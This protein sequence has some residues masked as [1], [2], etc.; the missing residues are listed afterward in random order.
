MN[1]SGFMQAIQNLGM[2]LITMMSG[3]VVDKMGYLWLEYFFIFWLAVALLGT[4]VIWVMDV[5]GS[6]YLNMGI[7]QREEHDGEV[8][9]REKAAA[10]AQLR[11]QNERRLAELMK[12][13]TVGQIRNR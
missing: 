9:R 4:L 1:V 12:P 6:G 5:F 11:E 13:L 8:K 2:A 10:A 7:A 3:W